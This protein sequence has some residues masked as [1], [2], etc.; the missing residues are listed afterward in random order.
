MENKPLTLVIPQLPQT[1]Q[2]KLREYG[3]KTLWL[4]ICPLSFHSVFFYWMWGINKPEKENSSHVVKP[5]LRPSSTRVTHLPT[6]CSAEASST[7]VLHTHPHTQ[8]HTHFQ[9]RGYIHRKPHAH[10]NRFTSLFFIGILL[11]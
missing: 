9:K 5:G 7:P 2:H 1:K 11:F 3:R 4:I 10:T 6:C 8:T